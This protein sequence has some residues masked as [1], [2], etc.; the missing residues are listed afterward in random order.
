MLTEIVH[1]PKIMTN[2]PSIIQPESFRK[3]L[4]SYLKNR[5]P[6]AFPSDVRSMLQ[7]LVVFC[8]VCVSCVW[9]TGI[10]TL[11]VGTELASVQ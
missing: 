1:P 11:L 6:V 9:H 4:D 10:N 3:D 7:V 2:V 8:V 5:S